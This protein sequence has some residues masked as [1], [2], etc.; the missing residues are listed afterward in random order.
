MK[1]WELPAEQLTAIVRELGLVETPHQ[2]LEQRLVETA[3]DGIVI[4][5]LSGLITFAN[6]AAERIL[7]LDHDAIAEHSYTNPTWTVLAVDG[8]PF[9]PDQ[10][11][12]TRVL[13][14]GE[15]VDEVEHAIT[16]RDGRRV[17][18]SINAAPLHDAEGAL[19]G[20]AAT[21]RDITS[22]HQANAALAARERHFRAL[23][24][25]SWDGVHL[26]NAHGTILWEGPAVQRIL[27]YAP[28]DLAVPAHSGV[29]LSQSSGVPALFGCASPKCR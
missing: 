17:V 5:D 8:G 25:R 24:E 9:P 21:I 22:A 10:L 23:V 16:H 14:S 20:V 1:R 7:D 2:A 27:G 11:P 29:W 18:L 4:V 12:V 26:V 3:A 19:T 28:E 13:R 15:P 6:D